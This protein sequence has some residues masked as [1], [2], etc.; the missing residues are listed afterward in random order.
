LLALCWCSTKRRQTSQKPQDYA[1]PKAMTGQRVFKKQIHRQRKQFDVVE[2]AGAA[3]SCSFA[4]SRACKRGPSTWARSC[5][6]AVFESKSA[7]PLLQHNSNISRNTNCSVLFACCA[8]QRVKQRH[9]RWLHSVRNA[10]L[11]D[12]YN[13]RSA[14]LSAH[15][16]AAALH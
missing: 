13:S 1:Q 14:C 7:T 6:F 12:A 16:L 2:S 3:L 15:A 11:F 9:P 5:G 10:I 8:V 4:S